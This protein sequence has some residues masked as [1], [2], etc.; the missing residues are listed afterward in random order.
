[1]TLSDWYCEN[2]ERIYCYF[3]SDADEWKAREIYGLLQ[4]FSLDRMDV[5]CTVWVTDYSL[6]EEIKITGK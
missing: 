6:T 5:S 1:M 3:R 4:R 2:T